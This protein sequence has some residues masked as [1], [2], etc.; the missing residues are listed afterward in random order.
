VQKNA[1]E[2][3]KW[4]TFAA[5]QGDMYAQTALAGM[6][7]H[8]LGVAQDMQT[9]I[10]W[11]RRAAEQGYLPAQFSLARLYESG[12]VPGM[13]ASEAAIWYYHAASQGHARAMARLAYM[14]ETG[15]GLPQDIKEAR[16]WYE[17]AIEEH[18]HTPSMVALASLFERG[19]TGA[20]NERDA[21]ALDLYT[22]A[23]EAGDG[24]AQMEMGRLYR[25]EGSAR[26][27][28]AEA[29]K[30]F[31]LAAEHLPE[32]ELRDAAIVERIETLNAMTAEEAADGRR[33]V[34]EWVATQQAAP[35]PAG[36]KDDAATSLRYDD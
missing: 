30:W 8:G 23:A 25:T 1:A 9:A 11:Y 16:R 19:L 7:R 31:A 2:A 3:V 12:D 6:Y 32:G 13:G 26:M 22:R 15:R 24:V 21:R 36:A 28:L 17:K 20:A 4:Y 10:D 34:S 14:Y 35:A 33:L 27:R 18:A 5:N 29:Y